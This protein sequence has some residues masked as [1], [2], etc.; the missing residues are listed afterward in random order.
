MLKI[1]NLLI[2]FVLTCGV[3]AH[4]LRDDVNSFDKVMHSPN[5]TPVLAQVKSNFNLLS[6]AT[7]TKGAH[8][9][10]RFLGAL[11][12]TGNKDAIEFHDRILSSGYHRDSTTLKALVGLTWSHAPLH[13][14]DEH[15]ISARFKAGGLISQTLGVHTFAEQQKPWHPHQASLLDSLTEAEKQ[16][17][18]L[19]S[20]IHNV[21][22][23]DTL[24]LG[25]DPFQKS[26]YESRQ[27]IFFN[28]RVQYVGNKA[29]IDFEEMERSGTKPNLA[30]EIWRD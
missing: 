1:T 26:V 21:L 17:Q 6:Q 2:I 27:S 13:D 9:L 25:M 23:P 8:H 12:K 11:L 10:Y 3:H 4:F 28:P 29:T 30:P 19:G 15:I 5:L 14:H 7:D 18:A 16:P 24:L 22:I 20:I